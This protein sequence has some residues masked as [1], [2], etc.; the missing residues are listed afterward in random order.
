VTTTVTVSLVSH[1][2][3][4]KTTL[5]RTL[6]KRDVGRVLDRAHVTEENESFVLAETPDARLVL[7]DTPG[8]GDTARL[9][10]RLVRESDPIAWFL[11]TVWDRVAD[12]PLWC[13]QQAV[14]NV[15]QEADVVLYLVNAAEDPEAAGY[16]RH[17]LDLLAWV[18]RP[19]LVLLNQTGEP[20]RDEAPLARWREFA[21]AWPIVADVLPLDAFTRCWVE[22]GRLLDRVAEVVAPEK[23]AA[24]RAL[25][26]AWGE[27]NRATFH[28]AVARLSEHLASAAADREPLARAG[29]APSS[30]L[31]DLWRAVAGAATR[32]T[33]PQRRAMAALGARLQASS[34]RLMADLLSLHGLD[35]R[36]AAAVERRVEDFAV[37][38]G[39]AARARRSATWGGILG[40]ALSG[41][42]ADLAAGGLTLGGG[43]I[44][45][46]IAGMLGGA[47]LARTVDLVGGRRD[48]SVAWSPAFLEE[49]FRQALLRYVAVAHFG[50]G[51]GEWRDAQEPARWRDAVAG[52]AAA[53]AEERGAV[54]ARARES[55]TDAVRAALEPVVLR[56]VREALRSLHPACETWI[57]S[58]GG[59]SVRS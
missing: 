55:G 31:A 46:A 33:P 21:K 30:R 51:R 12:R 15:K 23:R 6:L 22:E 9:A 37:E 34:E 36:S 7:W 57:E 4:G 49:L 17:E 3:V 39:S 44:L 58:P 1:T 26:D 53:G 43:M 14:R 48:P 10:R 25:A 29:E 5:A 52:A 19:T 8:F 38:G 28:E 56:S 20:G 11:R 45:G 40:G 16:P 32:V 50:R 42:A 47:G 18:G 41:L 27:T 2:N 24:A 54:L 35:G 13:G 59:P